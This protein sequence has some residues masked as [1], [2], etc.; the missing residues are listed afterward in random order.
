MK[1]K[2]NLAKIHIEGLV[3]IDSSGGDW[4]R[5][6]ERLVESEGVY[7]SGISL[8]NKIKRECTSKMGT[9]I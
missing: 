5:P 9:C 2:N 4:R 8:E 3:F 6:L 1:S 7:F